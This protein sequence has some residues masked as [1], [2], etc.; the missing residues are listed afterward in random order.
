MEFRYL[1][2]SGLKISE[3]TYGNWLT[4]GSQVENDVATQCVRAALDAGITTFDT[5][6]TYANTAAET[7]LGEALK[8]ERRQSLE[9]FTKVYWPTGPKGHNDVGLSRK[10][11]ME[12]INGSLERL[13]TD[14][15]D[16]YQAHRYDYETP[17]EETMQAFADVVRQGKALYIG[18]SE[19]SAEQIRAGAAL[20]KELGFQLISNQPQYSMLWRVIEG[21][22][23]P[24]S[25]QL[26]L[27]Q[28]VWSP[29]AQGVLTGKYKP[30]QPLPE[31]SRATDEKGGA[32]MIKRFM[33]DEVLEAVQRL[34]P[35]ADQAGLTLAQLAIAWTLQN[36]NVASAIVGASR[37]QQVTDNVKAAGV[38]LDTDAL[39][40]IDE[41]LGDIPERDASKNVSPSS[42]PA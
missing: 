28:I 27:S 15:V 19:W 18:V 8:G 25:K 32:D 12:S 41:A 16:L 26:G 17:L 39:A 11:I 6:D 14:Y 36:D 37:P 4:H 10:H 34:Q 30:G 5:A 40:A 20:A 23:V 2:N 35:V 22:V 42:R 3:I 38:K 29:I 31:G 7:V 33:R 13:Q 24:A 21:E 1:G 9:V